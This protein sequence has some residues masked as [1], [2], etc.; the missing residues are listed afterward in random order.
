MSN[1]ITGLVPTL[2]AN[3]DVVSRELVGF[4]TAANRDASIERAALNQTVRVYTT[5]SNATQSYT[6]AAATPDTGDQTLG[7]VDITISKSK[8]APF[9]W[10]GEEQRGL[11]ANGPGARP[12]MSDQIQQA[13]RVLV[14]EMEADLAAAAG[15]GF[16]RAYGTAGSDPFASD[17]SSS[18]QIRKIL[19]DNGAPAGG[20]ACIINTAAGASMRTLSQLTKANEA[21][22]TMTLRDGELLN[23]HGISFKE[24]AQVTRPA[25]GTS[26][27][28]GTTD[29]TGYAI[30]STTITMAAAGTGTALAGDIITISGDTNK[31]ILATGIASLAAG[32][33]IVLAA[34]GLRQAI[35]ASA[36][37]VTVVALASRNAAFSQNALQFVARLPALP[38]GGDIASDRTT[39]VDPRS[40]MAFEIAAYPQFRQMLYTIGAAW[41]WKVIKPEHGAILIGA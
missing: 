21:A 9:R 12:I 1:T 20:R 39:I 5:P 14:N 13:M 19:D 6:A 30:G 36:K 8:F 18:A 37:T 7:S 32:G 22:T 41:G 29:A 3:L 15:I 31:Y 35:P 11:N 33:T 40:G 24:S 28:S 2:Y 27:N 26:N 17:L 23:L 10:N 4:V 16:S 34:P 25:I 38:D